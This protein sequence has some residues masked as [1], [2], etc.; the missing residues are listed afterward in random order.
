MFSSQ[1]LGPLG[2]DDVTAGA[3]G[4]TQ[5]MGGECEGLLP[6][7]HPHPALKV[8]DLPLVEPY[9]FGLSIDLGKVPP[10]LSRKELSIMSPL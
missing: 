9:T 6:P 1:V 7:L 3:A 5:L 10:T 4:H 8:P 2:W